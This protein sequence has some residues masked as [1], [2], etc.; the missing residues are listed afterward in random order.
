MLDYEH[1]RE[2]Y[3]IDVELRYTLVELNTLGGTTDGLKGSS[4][5]NSASVWA[6]W[7]APTETSVL[8]RPLRYVLEFSNTAFFGPQRG[9]LGINH[10]TSLGAGIE[11][12]SSAYSVVVTRTRLLGRYMFGN[13]VSGFSLGLAVSF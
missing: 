6:R 4:Q 8:Q 12:D 7:R 13:N 3:E 2:D 1:Y 9:A 10:L 5:N 11:L